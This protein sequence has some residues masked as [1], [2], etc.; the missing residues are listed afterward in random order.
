M[1]PNFKP[2]RALRALVGC[3]WL[4]LAELAT[5][6]PAAVAYDLS[7]NPTA[8]TPAA[9]TLPSID[10]SPQAELIGSNSFASFSVV[11]AGSGLSYQWLSNGIP[12]IG[13]TGDSLL[14]ANI[15]LVGTN[16]GSFSVII[17]NDSGSV[18]SAPAA[19]WSD[20]NGN[21]IPDWWEM[22]YFKNL[23]QP[24]LGD[25]DG[26]GVDNLDE[27][28]EGTNP[29]NRFSFDPRLYVQASRGYVTASPDLPYFIM[30]SLVTMSAYP[31]P[32]QDFVGW[33]GAATGTKSSI[34]LFM[35]TNES[36]TANFG[37]SL[38]VALDNTN[39]VWTTT[40][41]ELWFGQTEVSEDGLG[42]AQSGPIVSYF[43]GNNFVGD[44]TSLQ[45]AFY[46]AQPE[47]L[48]FWWDVSS[49]PP[50][51]VTFSINS[52]IV[53]TLSGQSVPWQYFQTNLPAGV[54]T[55]DWTYSKGPVNIPNG[56]TYSDAAWV[57]Q[58]SL[59]S[60]APPPP[61][62]GIQS[63]GANALLLFW[64]VSSA[65]FRLQQSASLNPAIWMDTTNAVS[66]ANAMNQ[67][68]VTPAGSNQFY[69]LVYP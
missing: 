38:G 66:V 10:S 36:V 65:T 17:S 53:A 61:V 33:S 2:G 20:V 15:A 19:L 31:D 4:W 49:Q 23:N 46:I 68:S 52:N 51:A 42:A 63:A 37:L 60:T 21:G 9:S 48:G 1:K 28:L 13:A 14:V 64:P 7:G 56:I 69:R 50:D 16:L 45:T 54:Y 43:D 41:D 39:L 12:I 55:L 11:A 29:T 44:H 24:A 32:G 22:Q 30:G 8:L 26:D 58:V 47:V 62:L 6:Q 18:T 25:F 59:E 27:Y 5:A 3:S 35:E 67:A 34:S 40:G 57:E